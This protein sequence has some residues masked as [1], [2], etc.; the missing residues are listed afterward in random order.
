MKTNS[1]QDYLELL[2]RLY[3]KSSFRASRRGYKASFYARTAKDY[4]SEL[5]SIGW[6]SSDTKEQIERM[7]K[8]YQDRMEIDGKL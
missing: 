5:A 3:V 7:I 8:I 1:D 2:V 4:Y 6:H